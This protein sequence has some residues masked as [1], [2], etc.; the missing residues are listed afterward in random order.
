MS[1]VYSTRFIEATALTDFAGYEV[2][3]GFRAVVRDAWVTNNASIAAISWSLGRNI[4]ATWWQQ[5]DVTTGPNYYYWQGRQVLEAGEELQF[6]SGGDA[7]DVAVCG[8]LL[9]LP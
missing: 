7:I 2:P 5:N 3:S 1:S 4:G 6:Y 8:Y 9:T